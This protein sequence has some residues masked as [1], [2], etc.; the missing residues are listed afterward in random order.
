MLMMIYEAYICETAKIRE[1]LIVALVFNVV[2][3]DVHV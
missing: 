2:V 3:L 1:V